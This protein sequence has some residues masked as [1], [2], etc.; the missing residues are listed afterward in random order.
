MLGLYENFPENIH[1][2]SN[3]G[4]TLSIQKL[5]QRLVQ[6]LYEVN[7]KPFSFEEISHPALCECTIIFE[8]GIAET[9][10]FNYIDD[11]EAKRVLE[12]LRKQTFQLL[13]FFV[14]VRYYKGNVPKKA[15]LRFDYYMVRF[16]FGTNNSVEM[17]VFHERGPRYISPEDIVNFVWKQVN[18]SSARKILKKVEPT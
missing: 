3:F 13:D 1:R 7:R 12:S 15:P 16:I 6:A 17:Q 18:G 2:V 10:S 11:E 9:N 5:Q 4:S 8:V 14:A